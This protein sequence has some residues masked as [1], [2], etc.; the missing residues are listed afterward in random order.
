MQLPYN[1]ESMIIKQLNIYNSN[2]AN[3]K[4][5]RIPPLQI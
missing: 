2:K 5:L 1:Q 3:A 4:Q